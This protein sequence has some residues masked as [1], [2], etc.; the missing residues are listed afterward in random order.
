MI[1]R[2]FASR[3]V[4]VD[5]DADACELAKKNVDANAAVARV[6]HGDVL[7]VARRLRGS[8]TRVVCNPPYFAEGAARARIA[9]PR[10][11]IGDLD[12]FARAT[13]E[14]LGHRGVA[15]YV[16]PA[17]GFAALLRSFRAFGLEAKRA[18]FVHATASA[19]A[20]VV[21]ASARVSK[22]GGLVVEA[23]LVE[24]VARDY[25]D[26]M[27]RILGLTREADRA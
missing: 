18:R 24:R 8:A 15:H 19:P 2:G 17:H 6:E 27:K 9:A 1:A 23:P 12:R 20:R 26:E 4:L 11:R 21:L 16:Y 3:A 14:I 7:E 10:A 25:T 22:P 13:R 5:A